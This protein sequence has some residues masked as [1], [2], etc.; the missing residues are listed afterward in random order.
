MRWKKNWKY[1]LRNKNVLFLLPSLAG[2]TFFVMVPFA[3]VV[4][5]SFCTAMSGEFVGIKNYATVLRNSAFRLAAAN[6]LRFMAAGLPLLLILSLGLALMIHRKPVYDR[7][8]Y[9]YL[10]PMAVPAATMVLVWK[11]LFSEQG[12]LNRALG[13]HVDFLGEKSAFL[14]LVISYLWKNLGYT[15]VLWLAGLKSIPGEII[16]AAKVDG[17]GK[18]Q[19]FFKVTLPCLKGSM[20]TILVVSILNSFKAFREVYLV[21]GAYPQK[22]IYMIQN[23]FNN[24]YVNLEQDKL[25]A[26]AVLLVAVLGTV[27]FLLRRQW[28]RED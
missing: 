26:G 11:L 3:K 12:F 17:A 5:S 19:V 23:V 13:T 22:S 2:V 7:Y 15:V 4:L 14:I 1:T 27:S 24:W 9:L 6:T 10:L 25:A 18:V 21:G 16:D 8:K 20:F 28:D